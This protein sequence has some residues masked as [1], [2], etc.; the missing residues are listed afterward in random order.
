[1]PEPN[2]KM[3]AHEALMRL[4]GLNPYMVFNMPESGVFFFTSRDV[5]FE[6]RVH[7]IRQDRWLGRTFALVE[8]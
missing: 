7:S 2:E 5:T 8:L 1:M 6:L 3:E 4:A